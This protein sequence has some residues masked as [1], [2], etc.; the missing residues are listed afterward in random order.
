[1]R[2][3]LRGISAL[4]GQGE[5]IDM[6]MAE[7]ATLG[8]LLRQLLKD[9]PDLNTTWNS[10]ETIERNALVMKNNVDIA[11]AGGLS[12]KLEEKDRIDIVPLVH[13]G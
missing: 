8:D 1:M 9:N 7:G 3:V 6:E 2:V 11:L 13:G 12:A 4:R 5:C 10:V